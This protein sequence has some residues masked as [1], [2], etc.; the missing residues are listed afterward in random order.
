MVGRGRGS[1]DPESNVTVQPGFYTDTL[2]KTPAGWRFKTREFWSASELA[3]D[4][5]LIPRPS[6]Q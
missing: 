5:G 1:P 2:V 3:Q 4:A 6:Q